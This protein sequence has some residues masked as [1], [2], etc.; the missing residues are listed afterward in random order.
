MHTHI[1]GSIGM[2]INAAEESS[3]GVLANVFHKKMTTSRMLIQE[4]SDVVNESSNEN[5]GAPLSLL[6][7]FKV[8]RNWTL[9]TRKK[10]YSQ[11]S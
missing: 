9:L 1:V 6:E 5:E 4:G 11:L 3:C 7:D 8:F 10:K 2:V